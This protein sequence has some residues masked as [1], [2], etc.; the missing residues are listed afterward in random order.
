MCAQYKELTFVVVLK[1]RSILS[2]HK[3]LRKEFCGENPKSSR[4]VSFEQLMILEMN[5]VQGW[6]SCLSTHLPPLWPALN[7]QTWRHIYICRWSLLLVLVPAPRVLMRVLQFSSLCKK[8]NTPNSTLILR[9][10]PQSVNPLNNNL[11]YL[12]VTIMIIKITHVE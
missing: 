7:S 5:G 9:W 1:C 8:N 12:M 3:A 4:F 2:W 6:R 10:G 11:T